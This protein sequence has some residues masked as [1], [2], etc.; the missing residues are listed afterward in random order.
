MLFFDIIHQQL[1][2]ANMI[3][4]DLIGTNIGARGE[5]DDAFYRVKVVTLHI[6]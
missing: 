2:P 4:S 6:F 5:W 1:T 3:A